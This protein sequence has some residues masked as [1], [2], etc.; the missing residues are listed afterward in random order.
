MTDLN[1]NPVAN[2][3]A[4][5]PSKWETTVKAFAENIGH[6]FDA[7]SAALE[8]L[9]G[10]ANDDGLAVLLDEK[11]L[12]FDELFEGLNAAGLKGAK[13]KVRNAVNKMRSSAPA[14]A[15]TLP[16]SNAPAIF[17]FGAVDILPSVQ[18]D[19]AWLDA[20]RTGGI[21]KVG[22]AAVTSG[23]RA[24]LAVRHRFFDIP[25]KLRKAME[26]QADALDEPV[27][28]DFFEVENLLTSRKNASLLN[29]I[30]GFKRRFV[31]DARRKQLIERLNTMLLPALKSFQDGLAAWMNS[32]QTGLNNPAM[33]LSIIAGGQAGFPPGMMQP[34]DVSGVLDSA[35]SVVNYINRAFAGHG[36]PVATA[37]AME[38]KDV[39]DI[40]EKST[41]PT[42]VGAANREDML[43]KLGVQV[44]SDYVRLEQNLVRFANSV[45]GL[46]KVPADNQIGF[47]TALYMLGQQIPFDTLATKP[48]KSASVGGSSNADD[49]EDEDVEEDEDEDDEELVG[50][51]SSRANGNGRA[52]A[53]S[54][55]KEERW[56]R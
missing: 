55:P 25:G 24:A 7:V 37:M 41:L 18:N 19:T 43:K 13:A 28:A 51:G 27:G 11:S 10:D 38:A 52:K 12:L 8:G 1:P 34:P 21:L 50:A 36:I 49:N 56:T 53:G 26:V 14:A 48:G 44:D 30:P 32:W 39:R 45:L 29:V 40:L 15:Q 42:L 23:I 35:E 33:L 4:A 54:T 2:P 3:A 20:L 5:A 6:P 17:N 31:T 16:T 9:V 22:E 47:L 46:N